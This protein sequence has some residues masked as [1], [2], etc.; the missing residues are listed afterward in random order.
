MPTFDVKF[1]GEHTISVIAVNERLAIADAVS[2]L[3]DE[4]SRGEEPE[5]EIV[6]IVVIP[7][8]DE[9]V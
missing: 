6:D 8:E 4:T 1:I 3:N 7:V 2:E 9:T 5:F